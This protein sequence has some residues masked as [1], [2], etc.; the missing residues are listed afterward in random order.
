MLVEKI[1]AA[2]SVKKQ[3]SPTVD[4]IRSR[5]SLFGTVCS[6]SAGRCDV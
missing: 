2:V 4:R 3:M 5:C 1:I 6:E